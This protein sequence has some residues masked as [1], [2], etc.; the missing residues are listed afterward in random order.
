LSRTYKHAGAERLAHT[1]LTVTYGM[2]RDRLPYREL[3][4]DDFERLNA[5]RLTRYHT[6]KLKS[7]GFEVTLK[8]TEQAA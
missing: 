5:D 1:I 7:L 8:P 6:K 2:L 3:G 4:L